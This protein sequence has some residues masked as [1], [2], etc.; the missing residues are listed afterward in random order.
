MNFWHED[1][2]TGFSDDDEMTLILVVTRASSVS[3]SLPPLVDI[4]LVVNVVF[5]RVTGVV[6]TVVETTDMVETTGVVE[7]TDVVFTGLAE[8]VVTISVTLSSLWMKEVVVLYLLIPG[9]GV[10][11]G[12]SGGMFVVS[13]TSNVVFSRSPSFVVLSEPESVG[14]IGVVTR[15]GGVGG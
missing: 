9:G 11:I 5:T 8:T 2:K 3:S 15:E 10:T 6:T 13:S 4:E 7:T 1:D 12:G 14:E